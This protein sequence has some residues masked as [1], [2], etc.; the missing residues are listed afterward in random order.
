MFSH[1]CALLPL[2][3]FLIV[4]PGLFYVSAKR[5]ASL[6]ETALCSIVWIHHNLTPVE[7]HLRCSFRLFLN[8]YCNRLCCNKYPLY[9]SLIVESKLRSQIVG[10]EPVRIAFVVWTAVDRLL[11]AEVIPAYIPNS[12]V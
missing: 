3:F 7:G 5:A 4:Y 2:A 6:F 8:L 12:H 10:S 9:T 1:H 11:S